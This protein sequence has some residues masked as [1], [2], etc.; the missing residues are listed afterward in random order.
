MTL[1]NRVAVI[2]GATGGLGQV[3]ARALT[4][5]GAKLALVSSNA[6]KLERL[7][8]ELGL[9]AGQGLTHAADLTGATSA[10]ETAA[11]VDGAFGRVDIVLHLVGGWTGG[12]SLA[13]S[14]PDDLDG[15][16]RQHVWTTLYLARAFAPRL[17]SNGWGRIITIS[18]HPR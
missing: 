6:Q 1:H 7:S 11:A 13:E 16:L 18:S 10:A 2:T 5:E 9:P 8:A 4:G 3:A 17:V 12:R 14:D 15:M